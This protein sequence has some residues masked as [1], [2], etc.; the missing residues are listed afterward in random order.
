M[1]TQQILGGIMFATPLVAIFVG[2][3][4]LLGREAV[5]ILLGICALFVWFFIAAKLIA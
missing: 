4:H 1:T 2:L 3:W 5:Y